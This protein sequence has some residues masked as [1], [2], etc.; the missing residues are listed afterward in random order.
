MLTGA[1][2][3]NDYDDLQMFQ[4][5]G[6]GV[7]G[8][9]NVDAETMGVELEAVWRP[10]AWPSLSLEFSYAW[11]ESEFKSGESLDQLNRTQGDPNLVH[12]KSIDGGV[13]QS[14]I[15]AVDQVLPLVG[16]AIAAGAAIPL[17]DGV[18]DNGIPVFF[19]RGFLDASGVATT[20][21]MPTNLKG[22]DLPN[23]PPHSVRLGAAHTWALAPGAFTLRYDY[24]W[25]DS[26][27]ARAFNTRGGGKAAQFAGQES[28]PRI[29]HTRYFAE[30]EHAR[31]GTDFFNRIASEADIRNRTHMLGCERSS[32]GLL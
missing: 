25:Q 11:L 19:S 3:F 30:K 22:N 5:T 1:L 10:I 14:Y 16:S 28:I 20:S 24:Y 2:F 31:L 23:A 17:P 32:C 4:T 15:A 13:S 6:P 29:S 12:L 21:G 27:Y 8:I 9:R 7:L 26:S 18:Y